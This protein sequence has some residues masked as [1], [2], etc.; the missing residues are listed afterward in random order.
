VERPESPPQAKI[1]KVETE[2][3]PKGFDEEVDIEVA[4]VQEVQEGED[5]ECYENVQDVERS[6]DLVLSQQTE[7]LVEELKNEIAI[8]VDRC[9][10]LEVR[11]Q[12]LEIYLREAI[13]KGVEVSEFL[14]WLLLLMLSHAFSWSIQYLV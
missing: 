6:S 8:L 9:E 11:N 14:I 2:T 12:E 1:R 13:Q 10:K 7:M 3:E 4:E 5:L